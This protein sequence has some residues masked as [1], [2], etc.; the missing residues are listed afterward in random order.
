LFI[1]VNPKFCSL[2]PGPIGSIKLAWKHFNSVWT[3]KKVH[4]M[5]RLMRIKP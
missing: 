3:R 5:L 1:E 4:I 2:D